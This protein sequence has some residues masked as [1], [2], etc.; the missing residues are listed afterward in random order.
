MQYPN[1]ELGCASTSGSIGH[2]AYELVTRGYPEV[3]KQKPWESFEL[4]EWLGVG[5]LASVREGGAGQRRWC[6]VPKRMASTR[7]QERLAW[8]QDAR[9]APMVELTGFLAYKCNVQS[10]GADSWPD[11]DQPPSAEL[12]EQWREA[13]KR[14]PADSQAGVKQLALSAWVDI[15]LAAQEAGEVLEWTMPRAL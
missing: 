9:T 6:V 10:G 5:G 1:Q 8:R 14:G 12:I 15:G 4:G 13:A 11:A 7:K 3:N 2:S